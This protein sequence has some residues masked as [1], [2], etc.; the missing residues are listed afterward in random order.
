VSVVLEPLEISGVVR[1]AS[2]PDHPHPHLAVFGSI[3]GN[4]PCGLR[5]IERLRAE[6]ESGALQLQQGTLYLVHGNPQA[7]EAHERH[8]RGGTD[9]NRLFDYRF[10][11]DLPSVYWVYEHYRALELKP[12]LDSVD[13]LLDLHSTTAPSPAFAIASP[14]PESQRF[15]DALGL[16]YV[17]HGWDGPG[18]LADRVVIAPLTR[19]GLPAVSVE[20]G[21]H[22]QPEA[23]DVAYA[24]LRRALDH[25]GLAPWPEQPAPLACTRLQLRAA[26]KR[27]SP[28]FKFVRP[29]ASMQQLAAGELIGRDEDM[30]LT[31]QRSCY[32]IMP[33]DDV[34]VG[35]DMIYLA[36]PL[37]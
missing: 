19:R 11:T 7:G 30:A 16:G 26:V 32:V 34:G 36:Q 28:R 14:L 1:L 24:C 20:C 25:L 3:H 2:G 4:E 22:Q 29:L 9:L 17:T 13:A 23:A 8:T 31:L 18:L 37:I 15:A 21:Q 5:A 27:P 33:N 35:D 12:L 10:M 6:V